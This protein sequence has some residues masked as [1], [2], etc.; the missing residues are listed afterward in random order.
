MTEYYTFYEDPG[1]GWLE[2]SK[3]ELKDLGITDDISKYSYMKGQLA[4]LEEDSDLG[5]FIRAREAAGN[6][7]DF[8]AT[9]R[10]Y[11]EGN[12]SPRN[13]TSYNNWPAIDVIRSPGYT[14]TI[15]D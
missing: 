9:N 7:F 11:V 1:H 12:Q 10:R 8:Q 13:L 5:V 6:P 3:Q 14:I 15:H 4:Y 2:V